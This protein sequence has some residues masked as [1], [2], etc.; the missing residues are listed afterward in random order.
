MEKLEGIESRVR[1]IE[2]TLEEIDADLHRSVRS[3]YRKKID[4]IEE[5]DEFLSQEEFED[6]VSA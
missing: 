3:E 1:R 2:T 5:E 6:A 4:A